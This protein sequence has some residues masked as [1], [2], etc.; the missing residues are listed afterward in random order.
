M[1]GDIAATAPGTLV[2]V[3]GTL[4]VREPLAAEFSQ[5]P[6]AYFRSEI[7]REETYY[8]RNS[9][10][11]SQRRTRTTTIYK[12]MKYGSCLIQDESGRVGIDFDGATVEAVQTLNE[13]TANPAG[14]SGIMAGVLSVVSGRNE[15]FRRIEHCSRRTSRST[16][17]PRCGRRTDRQAG[18][19][20]EEQDLHRQPQIRGR[21]HQEPRMDPHW[22]LLGAIVFL[23]AVV[24]PHRPEDE[25][26]ETA[27]TPRA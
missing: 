5:K 20:L 13:P 8:E 12:T 18:G 23:I 9:K 6:A 1:G 17:S 26:L 24:L 21:A 2:E 11:E 15:T 7:E 27:F 10:G 22:I 3:K 19:G 16:S 25:D 14:S 4:R